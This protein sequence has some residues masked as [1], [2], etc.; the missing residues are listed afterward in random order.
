M[1]KLGSYC[2]GFHEILIFEDFSKLYQ[3]IQVSLKSGKNNGALYMQTYVHLY[4]AH[5]FLE[6][7]VSD[8]S[9]NENQNI[10]FIYLFL[11]ESCPLWDNVEKQSIA[12]QATD[13][14]MAH[15]LCVLDT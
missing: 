12:G 1:E 2:A 13:D 11:G 10:L 9:C 3:K 14:N 8:K 4:I 5:F 7:H 6:W 15:A